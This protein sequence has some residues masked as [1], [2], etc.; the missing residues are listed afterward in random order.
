MRPDIVSASSNSP[1]KERHGPGGKIK[2]VRTAS[3]EEPPSTDLGTSNR[4][5][6][7][8]C[9]APGLTLTAIVFKGCPSGPM[10]TT[11][12]S[13]AAL[14]GFATFTRTV[15]IEVMVTAPNSKD[16]NTAPWDCIAIPQRS[17]V[18]ASTVFFITL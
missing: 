13:H 17:I 2:F 14:V 1:I 16:G 6:L 7:A 12:P 3:R 10:K 5:K 8:D 11:E 9:V 18:A 15:S 4:L